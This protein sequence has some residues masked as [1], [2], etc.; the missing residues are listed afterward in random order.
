MDAFFLSRELERTIAMEKEK[1]MELSKDRQALQDIPSSVV[2]MT[3]AQ[4]NNLQGARAET[5]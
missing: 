2:S 3:T 1:G 4:H 5:T